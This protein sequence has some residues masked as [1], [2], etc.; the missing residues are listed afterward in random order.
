[1]EAALSHDDDYTGPR[2]INVGPDQQRRRHQ[3]PQYAEDI[4]TA[5]GIVQ[6][7]CECWDYVNS[8]SLSLVTEIA[9]AIYEARLEGQAEK[10][11]E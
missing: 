6:R 2:R 3:D 5:R 1:M 4:K 10:D 9:K 8:P 11:E 7:V